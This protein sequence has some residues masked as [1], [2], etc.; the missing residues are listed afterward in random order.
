MSVAAMLRFGVSLSAFVV[1]VG[2]ALW[3]RHPW[4][5]N[6]DY[7]HFHPG[8]PALRTLTGVVQGSIDFAPESIIQLGLI[9]LIATPVARVLFCVIGFARQ[10]NLLYVGV[11][12]VVL[13]ILIY[14]LVRGGQ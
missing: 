1:L 14:S 12:T 3:L 13:T 2:G 11:S 6:P 9:V 4:G 8:N 7:T 5:V 10:K